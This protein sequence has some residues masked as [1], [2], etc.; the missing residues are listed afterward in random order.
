M[1]TSLR[2]RARSPLAQ[3]AFRYTIVSIVSVAVFQVSI[4]VLYGLLSW[5]AKSSTILGSIIGGIPSYYLNR[6]WAWGKTGRSHLWR[7]VVPFWVIAF[8]GLVFSTWAADF[9]ESH[10]V[11]LTSSRVGQALVVMAATLSAYGVLWIGKFIL[12]NKVLFVHDHV[13]P[14]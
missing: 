13:E 6:R 5:T 3:R 12:F 11:S 14:V 8:I 2:A 1:V 9:S 7:E 10:A 4:F